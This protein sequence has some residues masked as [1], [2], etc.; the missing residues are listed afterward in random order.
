M[1]DAKISALSSAASLDGTEDV[2]A[3]QSSATVK[4]TTQ[5]IANL[6]SDSG[7]SNTYTFGGGSTGDIASM[8]FVN[9]YLT[10]VTLVP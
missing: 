9:G 4:T 3:V 6:G 10:A 5:D 1:A 8:T 7:L 2:P